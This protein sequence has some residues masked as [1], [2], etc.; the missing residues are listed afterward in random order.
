[1]RKGVSPRRP[2]GDNRVTQNHTNAGV[3]TMPRILRVNNAD[4]DPVGTAES[5]EG[6][7][8][9]VESLG[10]GRY[11]VDEISADPLPSGHMARWWGVG[12]KRH[13]GTVAIEPDP[14]P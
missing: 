2:I 12:I 1:L 9:V 5:H 4:G 14:W 6:V 3:P 7:K 11:H 8:R 13:D 10:S